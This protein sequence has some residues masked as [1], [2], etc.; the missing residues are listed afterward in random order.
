M[1]TSDTEAIKEYHFHIYFGLDDPESRAKAMKIREGLENL[2]A[3]NLLK[4]SLN[5]VRIKED[6]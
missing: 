5:R 2:I 3:K 6:I 1:N 4:I